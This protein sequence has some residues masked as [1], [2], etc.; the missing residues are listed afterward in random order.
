MYRLRDYGVPS[1][2]FN[3]QKW[4]RPPSEW[5]TWVISARKAMKKAGR[6]ADAGGPYE[7]VASEAVGPQ[8]LYR[9]RGR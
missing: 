8:T 1:R 9:F 6:S 4:N 2:P 3:G 5:P 7:A